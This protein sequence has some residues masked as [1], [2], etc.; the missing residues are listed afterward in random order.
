MNK[1][2]NILAYKAANP[3]A[4]AKEIAKKFKTKVQYVYTTLYMDRKSKEAARAQKESGPVKVAK[5]D[6]RMPKFE[7]RPVIVH[8]HNDAIQVLQNKVDDLRK[9][10]EEL[11]VVIAYLE[12]RCARAEAKNGTSV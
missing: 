12:H 10:I 1:A 2:Q 6:P 5:N 8:S 4:T 7:P 11:T 9:E 3:H